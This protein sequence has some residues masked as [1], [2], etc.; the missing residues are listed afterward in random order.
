MIALALSFPT[1]AGAQT[2]APQPT[3]AQVKAAVESAKPNLRQKRSIKTMVDN[4]KSATNGATPA[5]KQAAAQT[6]MGGLMS[7][8]SP[9]Q[10]AEFKQSLATQMGQ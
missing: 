6:L 3:Q 9:G 10:Q 7:V 8:L 4:Y 1:L 5:Q 2:A